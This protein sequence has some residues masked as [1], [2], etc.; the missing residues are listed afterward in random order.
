[1]PGGK[2]AAEWPSIQAALIERAK[3]RVTIYPE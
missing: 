1:M 3:K 2:H